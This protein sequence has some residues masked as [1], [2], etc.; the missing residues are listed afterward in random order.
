MYVVSAM[1]SFVMT[2]SSLY[3]V[4]IGTPLP[5]RRW[6]PSQVLL[7]NG[8]GAFDASY[9]DFKGSNAAWNV[10]SLS[11]GYDAG[12]LTCASYMGSMRYSLCQST[13][14]RMPSA[15]CHGS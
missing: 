7:W 13:L 3:C 6:Q 15:N 2:G 1:Y 11:Q 5:L 4:L 12:F 14:P 10:R 9:F 8:A